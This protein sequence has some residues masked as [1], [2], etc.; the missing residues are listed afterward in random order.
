[1]I[2]GKARAAYRRLHYKEFSAPFKVVFAVEFRE[3][4]SKRARFRLPVAFLFHH[5]YIVLARQA[6]IEI[7]VAVS[8]FRDVRR[9][10]F[11]E[12]EYGRIFFVVL[13]VARAAT[14][15]VG[16]SGDYH[17]VEFFVFMVR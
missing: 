2:F 12:F 14:L 5:V 4:I 6:D 17:D 15:R 10:R 13:R 8:R 1:M 3:F 16:L 9:K 11:G 7:F